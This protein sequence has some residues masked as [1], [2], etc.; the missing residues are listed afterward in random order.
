MRC[1]RPDLTTSAN[2]SAFAESDAASPSSAGSS[3]EWTS[4]SAARW[5]ADGNT[6]L[7][8]WPMLTWSLGWAGSPA[9]LAITSLA[10]MFDE[11]PEPVWKT[12]IG[13]WS[14]C[15]PSATASPAA[16][17]RSPRSASSCPSSALTRA[18][19]AL[20]RPSQRITGTGTG[21][22]DT[23]KFSTALAVSGPQSSDCVSVDGVMQPRLSSR[24]PSE[25]WAQRLPC[26]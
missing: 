8:D 13:N 25:V 6:S 3:S 2:S 16:A 12:S 26:P 17:I 18:A 1:V 23:G 14:S 7:E 9:M 4:P 10:F 24:G 11:V 20:R 21:C 5:T 15:S 22:P 19:A